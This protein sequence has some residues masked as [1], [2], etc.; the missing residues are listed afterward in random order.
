MEINIH[1][2]DKIVEIWLK[3]AERNDPQ[4]KARLAPLYRNY[5]EKNFMVVVFQSGEHDLYQATKDLLLYNRR[6]FAE[7]E[8][9]KVN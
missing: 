4:I 6:H 5:K 7:L 9:N 3:R 1:N 2:N 8:A